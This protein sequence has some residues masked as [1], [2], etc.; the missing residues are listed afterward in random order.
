MA[1]NPLLAD[2]DAGD[3]TSVSIA[4][5]TLGYFYPKG[6]GIMNDEVDPSDLEIKPLGIMAEMIAR[7][8]FVLASGK[9]IPRIIRSICPA[10]YKPEELCEVDI[11]A[12][13]LAC[14]LASYGHE[15]TIEHVCENPEVRKDKTEDGEEVRTPICNERNKL[16]IDLHHH[17]QRYA[18]LENLEGLLMDFPELRNQKVHLKPV[19]YKAALMVLRNTLSINRIYESI[20]EKDASALLENEEVMSTYEKII[21]STSDTRFALT[22]G[23]IFYVANAMGEKVF[24]EEFIAEWLQMVPSKIVEKMR[25]KVSEYNT[26][27]TKLSEIHYVC[28]NCGYENTTALETDPQKIFF[29]SPEDSKPEMISSDISMKNVSKKKA[30]SKT[31]PKSARHFKGRSSTTISKEHHPE[32]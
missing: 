4:L 12:I 5:P 17:I 15:M 30:P 31:S 28:S 3:I 21:D 22:L 23:S 20:S 8:P 32:K 14:R 7:D 27:L 24:N 9:G 13:L 25:T 16:L 11:E 18:P 1:I 10:I 2:L 6:S 26:K 29:Y 19:S